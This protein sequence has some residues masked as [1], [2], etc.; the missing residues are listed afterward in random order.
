[1]ELHPSQAQAATWHLRPSPLGRPT[2]PMMPTLLHHVSDLK[3]RLLGTALAVQ[4]LRLCASTAGDM[5]L[6]PGQRTKISHAV[7][8]KKKGTTYLIDQISF[9]KH[10]FLLLL[11]PSLPGTPSN[12]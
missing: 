10:L 3:D 8:P 7:Q 5:G 2:Q 4:W 1:M 6:I 12:S 11:L 9:S